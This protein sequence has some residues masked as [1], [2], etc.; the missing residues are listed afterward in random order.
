MVQEI[1]QLGRLQNATKQGIY[2]HSC[3]SEMEQPTPI[4]AIAIAD[5]FLGLHCLAWLASL[6]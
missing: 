5:A 3:C 1:P 2:Y 6:G 4:T